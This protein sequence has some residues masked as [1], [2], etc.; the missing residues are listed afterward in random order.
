M[1]GDLKKILSRAPD[2]SET[3]FIDAANKLLVNQF[4]YADKPSHR[5]HYFLIAGH[6]DYFADLFEAIGWSLTYQA[7]EAFIGIQ[8]RRALPATAHRRVPVPALSAAAVRGA[9]GKLRCGR[10]QGLY[11][12]R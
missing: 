2:V 3:D 4:L 9:V 10:R 11:P 8:G 7:D 1:L 6:V 5:P 12:F